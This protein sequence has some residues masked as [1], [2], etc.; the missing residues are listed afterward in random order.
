MDYIN[1]I[2]KT[3]DYIEAN[4]KE[5]LDINRAI[6]ESGY[7]LTHFYR[8]IQ[9]FSGIS[10]KDYIRN[11]R[12]SEAA[13]AL[14]M[15]N[16]RIIDIAMEYDFQ[17]QEVF[18]RAFL[19]LFGITPGKY[20]KSRESIT[21]YD[22]LNAQQLFMSLNG[23]SIE[24]TIILKKQFQLIGITRTVHP[25][26]KEISQ[27]WRE[28]HRRSDLIEISLNSDKLIGLCEYMPDITDDSE[29]S[30]MACKEVLSTD[31]IPTGMNAK[32][33][34]CTK[35]AVFTH[36]GTMDRLKETYD[37]IYGVWLPLTGRQLAEADTLEIYS[38]QSTDN[39]KL[40]I[41]VP[42]K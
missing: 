29:F 9:S 36:S 38:L 8:I 35:Y 42:L 37:K 1:S 25:G 2:Q 33:I 22:K 13:V 21:L 11:R 30:Y 14:R 40:D 7:S 27:L 28:F 32:I 16:T 20:R 34:P 15:S 23:L 4:L 6:S 3:I 10:L 18:T 31:N 24:P 26:S 5:E 19:R 39:Y 17:S 12:L 41:Y